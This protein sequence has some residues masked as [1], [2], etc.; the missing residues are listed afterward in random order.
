M[1]ESC[2]LKL[3]SAD[4]LLLKEDASSARFSVMALSTSM[5]SAI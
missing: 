4:A 1:N 2:G 3:L 5:T